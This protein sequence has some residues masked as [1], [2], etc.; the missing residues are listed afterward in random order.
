[1]NPDWHILPLD[2]RIRLLRGGRFPAFKGV[3][4]RGAF[5][6]EFRKT[7]CTTRLPSCE[8]CDLLRTCAFPYVFATLAEPSTDAALRSHRTHAPHPFAIRAP[9]DSREAI[10][11][12]TEWLFRF[13]LIG[14]ARNLLPYFVHTF[15]RLEKAGLGPDRVP[16]D[17]L[18]VTAITDDPMTR[19]PDDPISRSPDST[20]W[21]VYRKGY[22]ALRY[23]PMSSG[24]PDSL[25]LP[26]PAGGGGNNS[27]AIRLAVTFKTLA[28]IKSEGR[29]VRELPFAVLARAALRRVSALHALYC[30]PLVERDNRPLLQAAEQV[31]TRES[32]LQPAALSRFSTRTRQRMVF[33]GVT[34]SVTFDGPI[35]VWWPILHAASAVNIGKGATFGFGVVELKVE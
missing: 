25:P 10:E 29:I 2:F 1:M 24:W 13:T 30:G 31:V 19:S 11:A 21:E 32:S 14:Q 34:G 27:T 4:L 9:D 8:K 22:S 5:G 20:A 23:P 35:S 26:P 6:A 33:D 7:V 15:V 28:R 12:G 18:S 17:L 3:V 16:F